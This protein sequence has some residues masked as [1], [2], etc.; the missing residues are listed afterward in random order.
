M[1]CPGCGGFLLTLPKG[2]I[3]SG[4]RIVGCKKCNTT[5]DHTYCSLTG[6]KAKLKQS[7]ISY[8]DY[9]L[10]TKVKCWKCDWEGLAW[11]LKNDVSCPKCE[12]F[13]H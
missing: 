3:G 11:E 1:H 10:K 2:R 12:S 5:Y 7:M 6:N 9:M 13:Y 4:W 8:K